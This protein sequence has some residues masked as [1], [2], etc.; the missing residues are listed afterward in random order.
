M[1]F[2][3]PLGDPEVSP[4]PIAAGVAFG[5][6]PLLVI[7]IFFW[8]ALAPPPKVKSHFVSSRR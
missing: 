7:V 5:I 3:K 1:A 2:Y 6:V 4:A 8:A